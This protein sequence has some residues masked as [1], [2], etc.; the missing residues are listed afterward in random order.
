M[1]NTI[2]A[3]LIHVV[4]FIIAA[5]TCGCIVAELITTKKNQGGYDYTWATYYLLTVTS[6]GA[7]QTLL[8]IFQS[9]IYE[10]GRPSVQECVFNGVLTLLLGFAFAW[11]LYQT[12][13]NSS[14]LPFLCSTD[15]FDMTIRCRLWQS[16]LVGCGVSALM[17]F[18]MTIFCI[19]LFRSRPLVLKELPEDFILSTPA[20]V[21]A[22]I[23]KQDADQRERD[24][25]EAEAEQRS[26]QDRQAQQQR[27]FSQR[28]I[29]QSRPSNQY[30]L[31]HQQSQQPMLPQSARS[32]TGQLR[33]QNSGYNLG[34]D[35]YQRVPVQSNYSDTTG[36]SYYNESYAFQQQSPYDAAYQHPNAARSTSPLAMNGYGAD[37][38]AGYM[39]APGTS[40]GQYTGYGDYA[41]GH[42]NPAET[43]DDPTSQEAQAHLAYANQLKEQQLYHQNMADV[44]T[45]QQQQRQQSRMQQ[46]QRQNSK[47]EDELQQPPQR[48]PPAS[49]STASLYTPPPS[50]GAQNNSIIP[51]LPVRASTS[52][53][54]GR[55]EVEQQHQQQYGAST[56]VNALTGM[57]TPPSNFSSS[58]IAGSPQ[59]YSDQLTVAESHYS[60]DRHKENLLGDLRRNRGGN[61]A[62][63]AQDSEEMESLQGY[64]VPLSQ[65]G[66]NADPRHAGSSNNL[67][68]NSSGYTPPPRSSTSRS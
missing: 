41:Y 35:P 6:I 30:M 40:N 68:H 29:M 38:S 58:R 26:M 63:G 34:Q 17:Y 42:F 64:K 65:Y 66:G 59:L 7:L 16:G 21:S 53:S 36:E 61:D 46:Q 10:N 28:P 19:I 14:P 55:P 37:A 20:T 24:R 31:Q 44:L 23:A 67:R 9:R 51:P 25:K 54:N 39:E 60:D 8:W 12:L 22:A 32:N 62:D 47:Q 50:T 4:M 43:F 56:S 57:M 52:S 1:I 3:R 27:Q 45:K 13:A 33:S 48:F 5:G 2:V 11:Q 49:G 18:A 15:S